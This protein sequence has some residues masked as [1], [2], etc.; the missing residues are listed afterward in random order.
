MKDLQWRRIDK[1]DRNFRE[2]MNSS[3]ELSHKREQLEP[4]SFFEGD[5]QGLRLAQ[6]EEHQKS[7]DTGVDRSKLQELANKLT[8]LPEDWKIFPKIRNLYKDRSKMVNEREILDWGMGEQLA[9]ASLLD[10]GTE[11]ELVD[12]M[13]DVAHSLIDTRLSWKKTTRSIFLSCILVTH[14]DC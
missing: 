3:L 7:P 4:T 1:I 14:K 11:L 5:W 2:Q 12:R 6:Q 13:F 10:E 8:T 9:Y